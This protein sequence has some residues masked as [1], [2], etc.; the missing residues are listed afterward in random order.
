MRCDQVRNDFSALID[1]E[2]DRGARA[3]CEAHAGACAECAALL[4]DLRRVRALVDGEIGAPR[5]GA[6]DAVMRAVASPAGRWAAR[7]WA[8]A[9]AAV[10]VVAALAGVALLR[11]EKPSAVRNVVAATQDLLDSVARA[12]LETG[13][14]ISAVP[15]G[16]AS[17]AHSMLLACA[18]DTAAQ[19]FSEIVGLGGEF[20]PRAAADA[21]SVLSRFLGS[22]PGGGEAD[23]GGE[24]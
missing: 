7:R 23:G 24:R 6:A 9:A 12:C 1:G 22:L 18:G 3:A 8:R 10:L 14:G 19:R 20:V 13:R 5:S 11:R 4:R 17:E 15:E 2:L 16:V 21:A